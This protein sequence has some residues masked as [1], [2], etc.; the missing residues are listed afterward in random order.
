MNTFIKATIIAIALSAGAVSAQADSSN[1]L[2][3]SIR[4]GAI[5]HPLGTDGAK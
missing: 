1:S 4:T 5:I 2:N 3:D